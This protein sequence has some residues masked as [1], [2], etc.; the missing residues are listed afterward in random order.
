MKGVLA[1]LAQRSTGRR[2]MVEALE[3]PV[4]TP[5]ERA[6][7]KRQAWELK[8]QAAAVHARREE[9]QLV[10]TQ[11]RDAAR[12]ENNRVIREAAKVADGKPLRFG[13]E[14]ELPR[15]GKLTRFEWGLRSSGAA[16]KVVGQVMKEFKERQGAV[17]VV[18]VK[19]AAEEG[20]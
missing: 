2:W 11:A 13:V 12:Q 19:L 9:V 5:Q 16:Q 14:I 18:S 20:R 1:V 8:H 3:A 15:R 7:R 6:E 4:L 17:R 10:E